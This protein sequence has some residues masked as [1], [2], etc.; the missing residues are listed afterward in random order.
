MSD[1]ERNITVILVRPEN[2]E[3]IGLVARNMKNTGFQNLSLVYKG[4]LPPKAYVTAVHAHNILDEVQF[5]PGVKQAT[6]NQQMVFAAS[7]KPRKNFSFMSLKESVEKIFRFPRSTKIGLLFGNERTGLT[8]EELVH[9]NFKFTI[10]QVSPQPSYNLGSAVLLTLF[11]IFTFPSFSGEAQ[12]D[13]PL[14]REKQ[15]ECIHQILNKLEQKR[16]IH[17]TN[18][19]HVTQMIYDL[20]GRMCITDKDRRLL[21]ALFSKGIR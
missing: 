17:E 11:R 19:R 10:P 2:P 1:L 8:S 5:F 4:P 13:K 16:F 14:S 9:S 18:K 15:E 3:N 20:I 21:L 12:E 7:S 6:E